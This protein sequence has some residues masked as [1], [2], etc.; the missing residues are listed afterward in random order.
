MCDAVSFCMLRLRIL[1]VRRN[2]LEE[3]D[4]STKIGKVEEITRKFFLPVF[5]FS[6]PYCIK[7]FLTT[8][9]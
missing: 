3:E 5:S 7:V 8:V 6:V 2:L 1:E 9:I 4:F